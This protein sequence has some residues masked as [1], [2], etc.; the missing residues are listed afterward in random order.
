M[1][2]PQFSGDLFSVLL[3]L[4]KEL[5]TGLQQA[6]ELCIGRGRNERAFERS[7][8]RPVVCDFVGDISLVEGRAAEF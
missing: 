2:L 6:L 4:P 8:H 1:F 3:V 5:E 7:V